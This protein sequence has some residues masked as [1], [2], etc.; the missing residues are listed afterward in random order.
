LSIEEINSILFEV[1]KKLQTETVKWGINLALTG[2]LAVHILRANVGDEPKDW[3]HKDIDVVVPDAQISGLIGLL[4]MLGYVKSPLSPKDDSF[5]VYQNLVFG[6][7]VSIN[8]VGVSSLISVEVG[9]AG[10]PYRIL[11]PHVLLEN[12]RKKWIAFNKNPK[13]ERSLRFLE[14]YIKSHHL[15]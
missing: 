10:H 8:I 1:A 14:N 6:M 5:Y 11:S 15:K 7:K 9:Y 2:G 4:K 12:I 3:K 13:I